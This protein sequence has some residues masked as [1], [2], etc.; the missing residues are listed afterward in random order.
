MKKIWL[1]AILLLL[2]IGLLS[3]TPSE[4]INGTPAFD[5]IVEKDP[6]KDFVLLVLSDPQVLTEWWSERETAPETRLL[7]DTVEDLVDITAPDLIVI[8]G[9]FTA[10]GEEAAFRG[11]GH[12]ID[13]LGIPWTT[14]WGNHDHTYEQYPDYAMSLEAMETLFSTEFK[15][16]LFK[17]GDPALGSGNFTIGIRERGKFVEA[18]VMMDT[19]GMQAYTLPD[20][21]QVTVESS[22]NE[23]QKQWYRDKIQ[24]M[25]QLGCHES[26]VVTHQPLTAHKA[27]LQAAIEDLDNYYALLTPDSTVW[28]EGW[29]KEY[30]ESSFGIFQKGCTSDDLGHIQPDDGMHELF[31]ELGHTK[32][33]ISGH[34]HENNASVLYDGIRY[35]HGLKTGGCAVSYWNYDFNQNGGTVVELRSTGVRYVYH[36]YVP[37]PKYFQRGD[38][39][40]GIHA[41][42]DPGA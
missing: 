32:N 8:T 1:G 23:A 7:T 13:S 29:Q 11:L 16:V 24:A 42:F 19:H 31:K 22:P 10:C 41:P 39:H 20:G 14:V 33:V 21:S 2:A 4:P 9:D 27:A 34:C 18:I 35:T 5:F 28:G 26:I 36:E 37:Y 40:G 15:N 25:K 12:Y 38:C 6:E 17:A 3:C 30:E